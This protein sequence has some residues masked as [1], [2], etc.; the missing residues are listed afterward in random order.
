MT[1]WSL[2][3]IKLEISLPATTSD[4]PM[5]LSSSVVNFGFF[6]LNV[7]EANRHKSVAMPSTTAPANGE[8]Y[9]RKKEGDLRLESHLLNMKFVFTC[10]SAEQSSKALPLC[11]SA[12]SSHQKNW[13]NLQT[14]QPP[15]S[16]A[17]VLSA[18][19]LGVVRPSTMSS[20][21]L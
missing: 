12:S 6:S 5:K 13:T 19:S 21:W 17:Q 11:V 8:T 9:K 14:Q 15:M 4:V 16:W 7:F 10:K 2:N 3:H 18:T 1:W 20:M